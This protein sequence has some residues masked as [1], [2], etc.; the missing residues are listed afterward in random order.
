M[1]ESINA[2]L[3]GLDLIDRGSRDL[4]SGRI[5]P[6][7]KS[8]NFLSRIE[9]ELPSKTYEKENSHQASDYPRS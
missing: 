8:Q 4:H 6:R 9:H 7:L 5:T 3:R 1:G 2:P